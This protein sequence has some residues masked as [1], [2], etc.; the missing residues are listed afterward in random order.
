MRKTL[1]YVKFRTIPLL[2]HTILIGNVN[3]KGDEG[4]GLE[5]LDVFEK[6]ANEYDETVHGSSIE[7]KEVFEGY[8]LLLDE[9]ASKSAGLVLEF[10]V[11]TGN[12]TNKLINQGLVVIGIEPS[13]AMREIA[14][15]KLP[16]EASVLDGD[17]LNYPLLTKKVDT[18]V[19]TYAFHHLT[20]E[21]KDKAI[22]Q[23]SNQL[24]INGKIVIADTVFEND[25][26]YFQMIDN[27][28]NRGYFKLARD[29][30]TEY[31]TTI[32]KLT[33]MFE[34]NGYSVQFKQW[35]RFVWVIEAVK[36]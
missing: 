7:Y 4:M 1:I 9:V 32:P 8:E 13:P 16:D 30:E 15:N 23:Y 22:A 20:D 28:K 5:F 25:A 3:L 26:A 2:I 34:K 36:I 6:W 24:S 10:G 29:L 17:F 18:I 12:L 31:Y 33:A 35:N 27:A 21:E 14:V 19:S 11:G